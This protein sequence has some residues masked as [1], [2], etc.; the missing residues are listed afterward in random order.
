MRA[1]LPSARGILLD[2]DVVR[3]ADG[4]LHECAMLRYD[5]NMAGT[6][7]NFMRIILPRPP[8]KQAGGG[9]QRSGTPEAERS[10]EEA[11]QRTTLGQRWKVLRRKRRKTLQ[12]RLESLERA[13]SAALPTL[14]RPGE[15]AD[16]MSFRADPRQEV[17]EDME[18]DWSDDDEGDDYGSLEQED[19]RDLLVL[20]TMRPTWKESLQAWTLN[21]E[22][23]VKKASKKN[24]I[25]TPQ[26][27]NTHIEH[28]FG[29][30]ETILRFGKVT[31]KRFS[32]DFRS[33]LTAMAALGIACSTFA[34][35]KGVA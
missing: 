4:R 10:A 17:Y 2:S 25:L 34:E 27:G 5:M 16:G 8:A 26:R 11:E 23:R 6:I 20:E 30:G 15:A 35:K 1:R 29:P 13:A 18:Q 12:E 33:P 14:R 31:K 19:V 21:F 3:G 24:F 7:P 22:G 28:E 9:T 32:C